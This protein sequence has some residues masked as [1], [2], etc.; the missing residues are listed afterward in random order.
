LFSSATVPFEGPWIVACHDDRAVLTFLVK[1]LREANCRVFQAYDG[2]ACYELALEIPTIQLLVVNSH[3]GAMDGPA[4]IERIRM[5][6]PHV[7]VLHVGDD[8]EGRLPQDVPT[9][10]EPFS[11]HQLLTAVSCLLPPD[12]K[13]PTM[14]DA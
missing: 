6:L 4:L 1:T 13:G 14:P 5:E 10:D 11:A 12:S 3:L 9:L 8:S 2:L 7:A